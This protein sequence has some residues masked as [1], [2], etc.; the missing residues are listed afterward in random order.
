MET[1]IKSIIDCFAENFKKYGKKFYIHSIFLR[2][3]AALLFALHGR[4]LPLERINFYF[5][6]IKKKTSAFS[7]FRWNFHFL[8]SALLALEDRGKKSFEDVF[9]AY[10]DLKKAGF[11]RSPYLVLLAHYLVQKAD[12]TNYG[13]LIKRS[14]IVY[15]GMKKNHRILTSQWFYLSAGVLAASENDA[16]LLLRKAEKHYRSLKKNFSASYQ[17]LELAYVLCL[18]NDFFDV[19]KKV[20]KIKEHLNEKGLK[21]Q[22]R[23]PLPLLGVLAF[24]PDESDK[25]AN[26]LDFAYQQLLKHKPF[27]NL[28]VPKQEILTYAAATVAWVHANA[29]DVQTSAVAFKDLIM[30]RLIQAIAVLSGEARATY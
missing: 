5:D 9:R 11:R 10:E 28:L 23:I 19:E 8:L 30:T 24:L 22:R 20:L 1:E 21:I 13:T 25:I 6:L 15:D 29:G 17:L 3:T 2:R 7:V 18:Y 26:Q 4:E 12:I 16:Q 27:N 14:K